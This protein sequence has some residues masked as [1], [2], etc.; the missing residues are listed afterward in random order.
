MPLN[1][2]LSIY[3]QFLSVKIEGI[4]ANLNNINVYQMS[5]IKHHFPPSILAN[6]SQILT[7]KMQSRAA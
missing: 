3:P 5:K 7:G 2:A 6:S 4:W 1:I